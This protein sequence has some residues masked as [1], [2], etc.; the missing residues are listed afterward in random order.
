VYSTKLITKCVTFTSDVVENATRSWEAIS[1]V[2]IICFFLAIV[3]V[4]DFFS[5]ISLEIVQQYFGRTS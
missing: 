4:V 5:E 3:E 2:T 1:R